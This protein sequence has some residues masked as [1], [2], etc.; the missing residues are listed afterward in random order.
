MSRSLVLAAWLALGMV[1]PASAQVR[2]VPE[3]AARDLPSTVLS[4]FEKACPGASITS[5]SQERQ[6]EKIVFRVEALDK[7][8]RRVR[9]YDPTGGLVEAA[10]QVDEPDLPAPVADAIRAQAKAQSRERDEDHPRRR[11][12]LRTDA[13][14]RAQDHDDRQSRRDHR[15]LQVAPPYA[16]VFCDLNVARPRIATPQTSSA[17]ACGHSVSIPTPFRKIPRTITR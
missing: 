1:A 17:S 2:A 12:A 10:E 4:A 15:Q 9:V 6:N 11:G 16:A 13:A 3:G 8:R 14:G 7:G 5:A